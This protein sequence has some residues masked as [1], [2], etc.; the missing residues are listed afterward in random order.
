MTTYFNVGKIVNTHGIKGEV[1][2]VRI[3]DFE[4]RFKPGQSLFLFQKNAL[5]PLIVTVKSHRMHKGFDMLMFEEYS[6]INEVEPL[7]ESILKITAD[8]QTPL[9]EHEYYYHEI[10]GCNVETTTGKK[11][12]EI[13]EILSPGANDV[14]VVKQA[15]QK[16]L[17][18]P[19]IEDVVKVVD[20]E[21]KRVTIE[22]MEGLL[23][24]ED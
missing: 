18:I 12:G 7:K 14:W 8:Y 3:T 24:D 13:K 4:D 15:G 19:Y 16:D 2:V 17:L 10:L 11:L 5:K 22:P 1:K 9:D 6:N 20:V 23:P 21:Q